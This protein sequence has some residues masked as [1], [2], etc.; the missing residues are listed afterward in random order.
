M[1]N[2]PKYLQLVATVQKLVP[3][4]DAPRQQHAINLITNC[5]R[6]FRGD[7]INI[8]VS[9][10]RASPFQYFS[11]RVIRTNGKIFYIYFQVD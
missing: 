9:L 4:W 5:I 8:D 11:E 7:I 3:K 2:D 1:S 10:I 6:R